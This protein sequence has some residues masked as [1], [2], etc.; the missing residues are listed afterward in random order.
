[1]ASRI[2]SLLAAPALSV[3]AVTVVTA[4]TLAPRLAH[5]AP[6]SPDL[7]NKLAAQ[8]AQ[9]EA[10]EQRT[11]FLVEGK[12]ESVDSAGNVD[13]V[14]EMQARVES[15]GKKQHVIV[16][17][18]LNAGKDETLDAQ[19]K[20]NEHAE[21]EKAK[22]EE[23]RKKEHKLSIPFAASEQAKYVFD[24]VEAD[25]SDPD[26]VR[27]T[28]T[29][30]EPTKETVEGSIWA[31]AKTGRPYST[32][33]KLS[34]PG[35]FVDFV[36]IQIELGAQTPLGPEVSRVTVDGAGG[37]LFIHK[38]FRGVANLHDYRVAP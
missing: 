10:T 15:D 30:K 14:K 6:P 24:Q 13:D 1:M 34:K 38:H 8:A 27:I 17:R 35:A 4:V 33:F 12:L 3:V 16:V 2:A 31:D 20:Q 36:H 9:L 18:Y 37:L 11:S 19:R 23:D 32:G 7:L 25:P 28:F 22:S 21:E 5:A 26:R 29:P